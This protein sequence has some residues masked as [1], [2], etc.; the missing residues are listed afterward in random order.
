MSVLFLFT[1]LYMAFYMRKWIIEL[2][3]EKRKPLAKVPEKPVDQ[4]IDIVGKSTSVFLAP[5][6]PAGIKPMMSEDLESEQQADVEFEPDISPDEVEISLNRSAILD[7]DELDDYADSI[8]DR[9]DLS[10]GLTFEQ[11]G[12]VL[13]VVEGRKSGEHDEH[14]AGETLSAM[15]AD[16]L[17]MICMQEEHESMVKK[18]IAGYLDNPNKLKAVKPITATIENFDINKYV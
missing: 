4:A 3:V 17:N 18:L 1:V 14:I 16:F 11:I 9:D 8:V 10:Q 6:T 13:E 7:A 2:K 12:H 15:P 5:L